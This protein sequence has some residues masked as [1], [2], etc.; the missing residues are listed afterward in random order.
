MKVKPT[1]AHI[2]NNLDWA[3]AM[4]AKVFSTFEWNDSEYGRGWLQA[5]LDEGVEAEGIRAYSPVVSESKINESVPAAW[6]NSTIIPVV[7]EGYEVLPVIDEETGEVLEE[8]YTVDP[9]YGE[10]RQKYWKEYT[11]AIE[12][13]GGYVLRYTSVAAD[14]NMRVK[15]L[16]SSQFS[17]WVNK[18]N[19]FS[20]EAEVQAIRIVEQ[21]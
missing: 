17:T 9:V 12:V 8:G 11:Q 3:P 4:L 10:E 7:E 13:T 19:G 5:I 2:K 1:A 21:I 18:F 15:N 20:T 6:P 16:N 14:E